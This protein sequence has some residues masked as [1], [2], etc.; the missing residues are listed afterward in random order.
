MNIPEI[1]KKRFWDK[2]D[3]TG[4]CWIWTASTR[5]GY[6]AFGYDGKTYRAHRFVL[7]LDGYWLPKGME[8]CHSCDDILCVNPDHLWVGTHK[9]NMEDMAEKGR[10]KKGMPVSKETR[11]KMSVARIGA[12]SS[13]SHKLNMSKGMKKYWRD[14][15]CT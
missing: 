9:E 5:A 10:S 15:K 6:G 2:V 8:V 7:L 14:K 4:E 1:T 12:K 3:K 11:F 13:K